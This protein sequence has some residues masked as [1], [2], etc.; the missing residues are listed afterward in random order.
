VTRPTEIL[1][2]VCKCDGSPRHCSLAGN[3]GHVV[4]E[5][6]HDIRLYPLSLAHRVVADDPLLSSRY[7]FIA[8][9]G[10]ARFQYK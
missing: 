7:A 2:E 1:A 4:L 9:M 10:A 3:T 5:M 8:R 6:Y